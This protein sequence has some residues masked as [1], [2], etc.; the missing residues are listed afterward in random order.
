MAVSKT[1]SIEHSI[2]KQRLYCRL[3]LEGKE[4]DGLQDRG[5]SVCQTWHFFAAFM[6]LRISFLQ[7]GRFSDTS[8]IFTL[9]FCTSSQKWT[10]LS[11][12]SPLTATNAVNSLQLL[13][14]RSVWRNATTSRDDETHL[15]F[16][17]FNR[18]TRHFNKKNFWN[19]V[20]SLYRK[21]C[22]PTNICSS[23]VEGTSKMTIVIHTK[24]Q[25]VKR[26]VFGTLG[27]TGGSFTLGSAL[28]LMTPALCLWS[29]FS[30]KLL[31]RWRTFLSASPYSHHLRNPSSR[32]FV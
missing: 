6:F 14:L 30:C 29:F 32:N 26:N 4:N 13:G 22:F 3:Q 28:S 12:V 21:N 11:S 31:R 15:L 17:I 7:H 2:T 23:I 1:W 10:L 25:E 9:N 19:N 5:V 24:T 8:C 18:E 20:P 27:D 16:R